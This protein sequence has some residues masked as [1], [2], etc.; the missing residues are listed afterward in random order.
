MLV[1]HVLNR[2][3]LDSGFDHVAIIPSASDHGSSPP[4][5]PWA[6]RKP[7]PGN[8]WFECIERNSRLRGIVAQARR[9]E[10]LCNV[11]L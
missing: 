8:G 7:E 6:I 10:S 3:S 9:N 11:Q 4:A 2:G 5:S 1:I